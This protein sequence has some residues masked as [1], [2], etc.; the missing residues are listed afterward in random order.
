MT[1]EPYNR[2]DSGEKLDL[3]LKRIAWLED[4]VFMGTKGQTQKPTEKTPSMHL[5]GKVTTSKPEVLAG[6]IFSL[7]IEVVNFGRTP[8]ALHGIE[9][10]IP[11]CGMELM[12]ASEEHLLEGAY[13]NLNGK[14]LEPSTTEKLRFTVR[15]L[16]KGRYAISPRVVYMVGEGV[17]KILGLNP[18]PVE[19]KEVAL[20]DRV[21]TGYMELDN[22][23]LG[24]L[25]EKY[26]VA[27]TSISCDETKLLINRFVEKGARDGETTFLITVETSR[28]EQ[29]AKEYPNVTLF[30]CN[31]Q[32][33]TTMETRSNV[34]KIR[35]VE[36][37][38]D[39]N[40][41]LFSTLRRLGE[42]RGKPRRICIE[43]VSDILLQHRAAQTR[44]WLTGLITELRS[45]GF[46][47]LALMNPYMHPAEDVQAVLDL[48]DG[49]IEVYESVNQKLLRIKRMYEQDYIENELPLR[50]N[51]L[52][53]TGVP[54]ELRYQRF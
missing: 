40:I 14:L 25:P 1:A 32:A 43:I 49:E 13:L 23:L 12:T 20:P 45:T 46:T 34:V 22:L 17:Q 27:L 37:L 24:G 41:P 31:P 21:N 36:S 54:R 52:L 28:W 6:E 16:R 4:M 2:T 29:L 35:G 53:T 3:L 18:A 42:S 44:R 47:I 33:E 39:I 26:S 30:V 50:R 7:E 9:E 38:T 19:V 8:I 48:F 15:A 11:C 51:K 5:Q 10:I